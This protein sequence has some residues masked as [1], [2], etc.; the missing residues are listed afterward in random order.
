MG[1]QKKA[2]T[3][4]NA[5]LC[6]KSI[7]TISAQIEKEAVS[8]FPECKDNLRRKKQYATQQSSAPLL[9]KEE[10]KNHTKGVWEIS[11]FGEG[12]GQH[13]AVPH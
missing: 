5:K 6:K 12:G 3:L 11:V 1:L 9:N 10:K 8:T 2:G 13:S 7:E 4:V